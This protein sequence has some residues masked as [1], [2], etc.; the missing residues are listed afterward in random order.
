MIKLKKLNLGFKRFLV[1]TG[2]FVTLF[3]AFIFLVGTRLYKYNILTE[4]KIEIWGRGERK[5]IKNF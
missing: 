1:K 4:W 5:Q 2:L 3:M